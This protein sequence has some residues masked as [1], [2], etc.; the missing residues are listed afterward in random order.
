MLMNKYGTINAGVLL[1]TTFLGERSYPNTP[2][3][4]ATIATLSP[5]FISTVSSL[6]RYV[7][8]R[9]IKQIDDPV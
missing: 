9:E 4:Y 6:S 3:I 7:Y 5:T 8:S 2:N 1:P